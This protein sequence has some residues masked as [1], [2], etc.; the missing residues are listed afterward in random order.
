VIRS[1]PSWAEHCSAW[2]ESPARKGAVLRDERIQEI[3]AARSLKKHLD[4]EMFV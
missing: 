3:F 2:K 4:R 1:Y